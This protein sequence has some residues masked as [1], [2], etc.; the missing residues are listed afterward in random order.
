MLTAEQLNDLRK[1]VLE[2]VPVDREL[3]RQARDQ[4]RQR[5]TA[6]TLGVKKKADAEAITDAVSNAGDALDF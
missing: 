1:K 2:G 5:N 6:A 3:L 4:L